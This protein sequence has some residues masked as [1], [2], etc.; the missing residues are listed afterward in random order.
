MFQFFI[1]TKEKIFNKKQIKYKVS[2]EDKNTLFEKTNTKMGLYANYLIVFLIIVSIVLV[3]LDTVPGFSKQ[4]H[5]IIFVLDLFISTVFAG[6]YFYRLK[7]SSNKSTFPFRLLNIFDFLSFA[8]F[9]YLVI[10]YWIESYTIFAM[11]RIFRVFRIF[12][13]IEKVPIALKL[14]RWFKT[15]KIEY[16]A[17]IFV[18]SI[19]LVVFSTIIYLIEYNFW[20]KEIFTSIPETLWW[21]VVTM[22]TVWYGDMV[23]SLWISKFLSW[24]L[25]FLWPMLITVLSTITV[26]IFI[27]STKIIDLNWKKRICKNCDILNENDAKYCK[28]CWKKIKK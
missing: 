26:I 5:S 27:E 18:I 16:L 13:L 11:F 19:V 10:V 25:M 24:F 15:H 20:N 7:N 14:F 8:P 2:D 12:E 22:T 28:K 23:P 21:W 4:Y 6:E 3:A 9:F 17:A 1:K